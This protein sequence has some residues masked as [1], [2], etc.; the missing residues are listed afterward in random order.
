M[1]VS[2]VAILARGVVLPACAWPNDRIS[3]AQIASANS[4]KKIFD[5]MVFL[6][7]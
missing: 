7:Y 6:I 3:A 4:A 5:F 1:F 2:A